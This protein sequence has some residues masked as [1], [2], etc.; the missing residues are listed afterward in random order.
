MEPRPRLQVIIAS[1]RPGRIGLPV[2][3]WAYERSVTHGSF[4][5]ELVDLAEVNL[6]LLDEPNHP[7]LSD[8]TQEHTRRFS[9]IISRADAFV[10]VVPEYNYGCSPTIV[11]ALDYLYHEW[12]YKPVGLVSYGGISGG[13]RGVQMLKQVLTTLKMPPLPEAVSI[14]FVQQYLEEG[15]FEPNEL[16]EESVVAMLTEL[17]RWT[18]AMRPL[19][20]Q[21]AS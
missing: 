2:G 9:A 6:P 13:T 18:A 5:V 10:F 8:Y 11:N 7:R 21:P 3:R 17:A 16:A 19:R 1:T 15:V 14:P 4:E 12:L 20:Q